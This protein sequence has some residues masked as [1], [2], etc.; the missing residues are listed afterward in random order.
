MAWVELNFIGLLL[1]AKVKTSG[2]WM[3]FMEEDEDK[4]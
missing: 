4:G 2:S 3:V 1:G